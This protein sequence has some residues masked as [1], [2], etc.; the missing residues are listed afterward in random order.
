MNRPHEIVGGTGYDGKGPDPFIRFRWLP[1]LPDA[2]Q[3]KRFAALL[4]DGIGAF[5]LDPLDRLPLKE[6]VY[7]DEASPSS[8][9]I[10][11]CGERSNGFSLGID[12]LSSTFRVDAPMR[13]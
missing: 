1:I 7:G 9:G 11:E 8:V 4:P 3:C 10:P 2:R 5:W 6:A 12:R 13:D